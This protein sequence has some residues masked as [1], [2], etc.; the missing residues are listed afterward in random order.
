MQVWTFDP[1]KLS[2]PILCLAFANCSA[3]VSGQN[4]LDKAAR[5]E[6]AYMEGE[7]PAMRKAFAQARATLDGFLRHAATPTQ[8][9]SG[10]A[11]KV[12]VSDGR[13][14]EYFWVG[15]L[16]RSGTSFSGELGNEPREVKKYKLGERFSF[17]R[18]QIAD[19]MYVDDSKKR[20]IG[21]FTACALLT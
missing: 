3:T 17:S 6:L 16:K 4:L 15:R 11:L 18:S 14:T 13:T 7:D 21:N 8:G 12:A 9:T 5:D 10:H 2:L 1:M 20:M 19:W